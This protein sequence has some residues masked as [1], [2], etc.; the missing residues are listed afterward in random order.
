MCEAE[1]QLLFHFIISVK[2]CV[3]SVWPC[4][5]HPRQTLS[6]LPLVLG[7]PPAHRAHWAPCFPSRCPWSP[8]RR[9][10]LPTLPREQGS[11]LLLEWERGIPSDMKRQKEAGS[12][13]ASW[14]SIN[15]PVIAP[16]DTPSSRSAILLIAPSFTSR[17]FVYQ[18][19]IPD[20]KF[21]AVSFPS[22]F[23]LEV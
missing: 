17:S 23:S 1:N 20:P 11:H 12:L 5:L 2:F 7:G 18:L 16:S 3:D 15:P 14:L 6:R 8:K 9:A 4:C 19:P 21:A 10:P 22:L 13:A